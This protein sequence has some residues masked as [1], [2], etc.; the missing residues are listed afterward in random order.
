MIE[1]NIWETNRIE[2]KKKKCL[3][4][5]KKEN[6]E[7][8]ANRF[9]AYRTAFSESGWSSTLVDNSG[10]SSWQG[11][12]EPQL[13]EPVGQ[14]RTISTLRINPFLNPEE[15]GTRMGGAEELESPSRRLGF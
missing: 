10:G 14:E 4:F 6:G 3:K 13:N 2:K 8:L 12:K 1:K 5:V 15:T 9:I 7:H 11:I